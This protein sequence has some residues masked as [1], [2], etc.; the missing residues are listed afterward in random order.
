M[1][2]KEGR[3][4]TIS[5]RFGFVLEYV[6]DVQEAKHFYVDVLGLE[7]EREHPMFIQFK[8]STGANYA[9]ASDEA[10]GSG[11]PEIYWIVDD[12]EA[13]YRDL[14]RRAEVS[15]PLEQLA[16]GKVFAINDPAGQPQFLLEFARDRPSQRVS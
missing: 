2:D 14:S 4:V 13:A 16:F 6:V 5:P 15:R 8:D 7:V 3:F 1:Q 12:A 9:I 10:L 11:A